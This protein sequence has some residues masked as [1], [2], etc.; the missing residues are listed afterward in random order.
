MCLIITFF[1][2]FSQF[3]SIIYYVYCYSNNS[4]NSTNNC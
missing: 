1:K 2:A 4:C 3:I